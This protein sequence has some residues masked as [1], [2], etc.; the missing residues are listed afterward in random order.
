MGIFQLLTVLHPGLIWGGIALLSAPIVL[1]L[2]MRQQPKHLEFPALRFIQ[3]RQISNRRR[4]KLR[5]L[6]LLLLRMLAIGLLALALARPSIKFSA[7][8][9]LAARFIGNQEAPVAAA[10]VFDT[11]PRMDYRLDNKTRL[12]IAAEYSSWLL[13]Q[14]PMDSEVAI[15]DG[16]RESARFQVDIGTAKQRVE[17]LETRAVHLSLADSISSACELLKESENERKEIYIFTD[18]AQTAWQAESPARWQQRFKVVEGIGFYVIDVGIDKPNNMALGELRLSS[19]VLAR[20]SPLTATTDISAI[21]NGGARA[22][23]AYLLDEKGT[24]EK[25]DQQSV[26]IAAGESQSAEFHLGRLE[27]GSY[28]GFV[29][30]EGTDNLEADNIRYFTVDV[31]PPWKI[32]VA[33]PAP[34]DEQALYLTEALMPDDYR[35]SGQAR[36][37]GS[38]VTF[39][40]L[41][42]QTLSDYAAVF[43]LDPPPLADAV[44]QQLSIYVQSGGGVA[45]FLGE[46]ARVKEFNEAAPQELMPAPLVSQARFP[47]GDV[48]LS[49]ENDQ[50]PLLT[51]FRPIRG[52]VPWESFPVFR[53]W[54]FEGLADGVGVVIPYNN[55]KPALLE[56]PP[57][58]LRKGRVLI[59]ST[60]ISERTN[61]AEADLWNLLPTGFR[62]WPFVMLAN[63]MALYLVGS[64]DTRLN[65][66]PGE[67]ANVPLEGAPGFS[68]YLLST[69]RDPQR[70]DKIGA[71]PTRTSI[72]VSRTEWPGNYAIRAG[73]DEGGVRRGFSVNLA[74]VESRL[75]RIDGDQLK[76]IFGDVEF[77]L[78][79]E[80]M[81]IERQVS[82]GRIGSEIFPWLILLLALVLCMEQVLANRFYTEK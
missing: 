46:N 66:L 41:A 55:H 53:Y 58:K 77:Y 39:D 24:P 68:T 56:K 20:N 32:L 57:G 54:Q 19:Q 71:D 64:T 8:S 3:Q 30:I 2:I 40:K 21:G 50:H 11:S 60:P 63:E 14:L 49:T 18:L 82:K 47:D 37:E 4:L 73:G 28:Q 70:P 80:K 72:A 10:L 51:K 42:E 23:E 27:P 5:H 59:L 43:L 26:Q 34:A 48:F 44:W 78:A 75:D 15:I 31:R 12:Q 38:V 81:Q 65:Y 17:K 79:R 67:I 61:A 36:F 29:R 13:G 76:E 1:H 33:A 69:P 62:P 16:K 7:S 9:S 35:K 25:R 45:I 52:A 74:T 22:I 6:L